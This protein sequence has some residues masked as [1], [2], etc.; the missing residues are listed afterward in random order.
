VRK[1]KG[2]RPKSLESESDR[3]GDA[4]SQTLILIQS[5]VQSANLAE[6]PIEDPLFEKS[7][8]DQGY[9]F[10][11]QHLCMKQRVHAQ[12][13]KTR[14]IEIYRQCYEQ[15]PVNPEGVIADF[16]AVYPQLSFEAEW[17]KGLVETQVGNRDF[18]PN[19]PRNRLFRAIATGFRRVANPAPRLNRSVRG[20]RL[21]AARFALKDIKEG[22]DRWER[23]L[24]RGTAASEWIA[25]R[26]TEK[27]EELV[28]S[29]SRL[30]AIEKK[31]K[32]CLE[33]RQL[34]DAA[35][36]IASKIYGVRVRAVENKQS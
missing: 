10:L 29:D 32:A 19:G 26:A 20:T 31:L 18:R 33:K 2:R 21:D 12:D 22:L 16:V 30:K 9:E 34:Y 25:E 27:A 3:V 23:T 1:R 28:A 24:V 7:L 13:M 17:L 11:L 5:L 4:N 8:A 6:Q 36:L 35:I 14:I 15:C